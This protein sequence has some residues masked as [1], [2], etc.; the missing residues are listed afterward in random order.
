MEISASWAGNVVDFRRLAG[1]VERGHAV[2]EAN[3]GMARRWP[4]FVVGR[5]RIEAL[6]GQWRVVRFIDVRVLHEGQEGKL[7]GVGDYGD[8]QDG[9]AR[10]HH[11]NAV[12][13]G[14]SN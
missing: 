12:V 13:T 1:G 9:V 4:V 10:S 2:C 7:G 11:G 14:V 5:L 3:V 6:S 8:E